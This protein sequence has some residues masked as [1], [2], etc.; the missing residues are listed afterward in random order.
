MRVRSRAD[1]GRCLIRPRGITI[2][3]LGMS[4]GSQAKQYMISRTAPT[5]QIPAWRR[6][7]AEC[8]TDPKELLELLQLPASLLPEARAAHRQFSI[9]VPKSFAAL[10]RRGDPQDPLLRQVLPIGDE[11]RAPEGFVAD[12]LDEASATLG[13]GLLQKYQGRVLLITSPACAVHC[14]YCF[15]REYP[16]A[17]NQSTRSNWQQALASIAADHSITEV[18]LSGGD[19]LSLDDHRLS[20]K[21]ADL[22][23][24]PHIRRLRIHTRLP[25]VIP[26]RITPELSAMLATTRLK[27]VIVLHSNHAQELQATLGER[28]KK[29]PPGIQLL[30]Q[31][32]LL[33]GVND[34]VESLQGLSETLFEF[35]VLP[36][37]LHLLDHTKGT[38]HFEVD[39]DRAMEIMQALRSRLPGYLIPRLV[40]EQAGMPSKTAVI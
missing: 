38:S 37:Y 28:L 6:Q 12:P 18:I 4:V 10:I 27:T 40:R 35:G 15:R 16:Y 21:I 2:G 7:M 39:E 33:K 9:R 11:L 23:K 22:D 34:S 17:D 25:V 5:C 26:E 13:N 3:I 1:T 31:S 20:A 30:N 29:L 36:Y 8:I 14:R 19:P 24:I 32:V